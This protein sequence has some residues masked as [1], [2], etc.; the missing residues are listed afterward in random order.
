M[1]AIENEELDI[2]VVDDDAPSANLIAELLRDEGYSVVEAHWATLALDS[3]Q[4]RRP[5]L[6]ITDITMP[7]MD[8][9]ELAQRVRQ[10]FAD[11]SVIF[12]SA[13]PEN[14]R[15]LPFGRGL[16]KP[17]HIDALLDVVKQHLPVPASLSTAA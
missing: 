14:L 11:I 9:F 4:R 3:I 7:G 6:L 5:R 1:R 13:Q 17:F 12:T 2:F 10:L 16:D 15:R 8:G